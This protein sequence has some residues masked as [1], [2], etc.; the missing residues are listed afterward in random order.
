LA[1]PERILILH[2]KAGAGHKR[3]AEAL[4]HAFRA[5]GPSNRVHALDTLAFAS[6]LFQRTY[7]QTYDAMVKRAPPLWRLLYWGTERPPVHRGTSR[8]RVSIDRLNLRRLVHAIRRFRPAAVVCTHFLPLEALAPIAAH[9]RLGA[10]LYCV[11][12]DFGAHPFWVYDGITGYFVATEGVREE[13]AEWGVPWERIHVTGIPIDPKFGKREPK[14]QARTALGLDPKSPVVLVMGGGNGVGPLHGLAERLLAIP[15]QPQVVVLAGRNE[16][17]RRRLG[18]LEQ[19]GPGRVKVLGFTNEVDRWLDAADVNVTKAGGLTCSE[20]LTKQVPLVIFRP[21]PGQEERNSEALTTAG[22]AL[23]ARTIEQ[24][25]ESV[26]RIL[27]H[28]SLA[29]SMRRA[30]EE[31][32]RPEAAAMIAAHVLEEVHGEMPAPLPSGSVR[33]RSG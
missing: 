14:E 15:S 27:S 30:C 10:P 22:A 8:A 26:E 9:G 28:P 32:G 23:R 6:A 24:V 11:I 25:T 12:T 1:E 2:A 29:R 31:L 20:S 18:D 21:T 3:A 33:V 19:A 13:L 7:A 5:V 16:A 17:L 4:E